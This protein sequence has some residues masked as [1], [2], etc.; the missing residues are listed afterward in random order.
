MKPIAYTYSHLRSC[1]Y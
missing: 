1:C